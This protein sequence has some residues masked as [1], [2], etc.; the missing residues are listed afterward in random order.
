MPASSS[1]TSFTPHYKFGPWKAKFDGL[2]SEGVLGG[3]KTYLLKP[4]TYMNLSGD[5]RRPGAALLQAAA[6]GAGGDP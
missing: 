6:G 5:L 1:W 2:L 3:R 4:Q